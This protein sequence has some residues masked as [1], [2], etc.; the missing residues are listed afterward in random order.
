MKSLNQ[1]LNESFEIAEEVNEG[2]KI[3]NE[4]E[5][6]SYAETVLKKAHGDGYDEKK[7]KSTMDGIVKDVDGD[8]GAAVGKLTSGLGEDVED[9][10]E[11]DEDE[12]NEGKEINNEKEFRSWG[13]TVLKK[14]FGDDYDEKKAKSTL[15]GL[16]KDVEG[17]EWGEAVG[18]LTSGLGEDVNESAGEDFDTKGMRRSDLTKVL[19]ILD[20]EDV[21]YSQDGDTLTFD[22]TV[23]NAK[24]QS[25]L[26]NL[27]GA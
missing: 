23:L 16:V 1:K 22:I 4:K 19:D 7:A 2:K 11:E 17:D 13:E 21:S 9:L 10:D 14:A 15:D 6:R 12:L 20:A 3:N 27:L 18:R 5:F 24:K 25:E 8:W 26:E